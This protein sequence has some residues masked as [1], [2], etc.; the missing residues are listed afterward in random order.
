MIFGKKF[1]LRCGEYT[2]PTRKPIKTTLRWSQLKFI[3]KNKTLYLQLS[4]FETKT[5][6]ENKLELLS[7]RCACDIDPELCVVHVMLQ[8]KLL[9]SKIFP[10]FDYVFK[11]KNHK[12]VI[13]NEFRRA[14][15]EAYIFAGI[16]PEPPFWRAHSL[17]HGEIADLK[18][19]GVD[20][21]TI[22]KFCRHAPGSKSTHLYT[23]IQSC[24]AAELMYDCYV[25]LNNATYN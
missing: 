23:N 17:R 8:W 22:Q 25:S 12:L 19:A 16:T 15:D 14:L 1:S 13:A 2:N 3:S 7:K 9:Y 18:A 21:D 5:N 10:S 11:H 6:K 20:W 24:E 4:L